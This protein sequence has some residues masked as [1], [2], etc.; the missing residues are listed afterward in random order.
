M[1]DKALAYAMYAEQKAREISTSHRNWTS[2]LKTASRMYK[3]SYYDQLLIH[4]QRPD[5]TACA[6]YELWNKRMQ[7]YI[8][9]GST[10][11]GLLDIDQEHTRLHYVFDVSDTG[12]RPGA[13]PVE[14]WSMNA[15]NETAVAIALA[16]TY[17]VSNQLPL[18]DQL[19]IIIA[20]MTR[21]YWMEH[22]EHLIGNI[23][24]SQLMGYDEGAIGSAF[25]RIAA[26]ST[27][28][29]IL[30]RCGYEP[31]KL[32]SPD[33]FKDVQ[34]FSTA[35]TIAG[36]GSAV[37]IN[38]GL[39]LR[40]I[41]RT[42]REYER[43]HEHDRTDLHPEGRLLL[44]ESDG[45]RTEDSAA[46]QVR[47]DAPD[48]LEGTLSS[49]AEQ[50]RTERDAVSAP[51]GDRQDRSGE[52]RPDDA[53]PDGAER[54]DGR[55]EAPGSDEVGGAD[56]QLPP[57]DRGDDSERTG[58]QLSEETT[59]DL[60]ESTPAA[61]EPPA[62]AA[63]TMEE[64]L[65]AVVRIQPDSEQLNLFDFPLLT[66]AEQ[67]ASINQA[68]SAPVPFAFPVAQSDIDHILRTGDNTRYHRQLIVSEF[69]KGK[70]PEQ[71][72]PLLKEVYHGGNGIV[73]EHGRI[74]AWYGE[75]G[76][77]VSKG[78]ASRYSQEKRCKNL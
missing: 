72:V 37:S 76:I 32:L 44:S 1:T 74:S 42:V 3:Y 69:S 9:R 78:N 55:T 52:N 53:H 59:E 50:T 23:D 68:E 64:A 10:G 13:V 30:N 40:Q 36:V 25:R 66:E 28:Y 17:G 12:A 35:D 65:Q 14:L 49:A 24:G 43:S 46:G 56:E 22:R 2:Y 75:D 34:L 47:T 61:E 27:L 67:I 70:S 63:P 48:I 5:A 45:G 62:S 26:A 54:R 29:T 20:G 31:D 57:A 6:S 33:D 4:A 21:D 11:I 15:D 16:D 41:E 7:R 18:P 60:S 71:L 38:S 58:V 8:K 51:D 39:V 19:T 73:T 77:R